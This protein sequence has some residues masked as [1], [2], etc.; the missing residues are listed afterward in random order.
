MQQLRAFLSFETVGRDSTP[1][2]PTGPMAAIDSED[3]EEPDKSEKCASSILTMLT[4]QLLQINDPQD[5]GR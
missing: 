4:E 3:F 2:R 1:I 5:L